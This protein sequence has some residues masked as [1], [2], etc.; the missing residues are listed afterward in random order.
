MYIMSALLPPFAKRISTT[1]RR[2]LEA[3][4]MQ[5]RGNIQK[6]EELLNERERAITSPSKAL[7]QM[8]R[9]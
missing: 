8:Y 5:L 3:Q 7:S 4:M 1:E 9:Y 2:R 6:A